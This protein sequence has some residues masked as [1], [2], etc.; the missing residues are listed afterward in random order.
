MSKSTR[1]NVLKGGLALGAATIGL[2]MAGSRVLAANEPIKIGIVAKL[3]IPWFDNIEVGIK[4]AAK[5]LDV[6][7]FMVFPPSDDAAQQVRAI[8][9]LIA[10]QVNVIGFMP[11]DA[12]ALEPVTQRAR[13]A[14]IIVIS[15]ELPGQKNV[16]WDIELIQDRAF[17]EAHMEAFAQAVGG[18]GKYVT[19]VGGLTVDVH[20]NWMDMAVEYQKA[21]YPDM[22]QIGDRF[23][24]ANSVEDSYRTAIDQ[25]RAHPD[26]A[27]IFI[28]GAAG[29]IGAGRAVQ[30]KERIGE[31][32]VVGPFIPSQGQKLMNAGAITRGF[33][34]N[35]Q[36]AG[37][38]LVALGK[39]LAEGGEVTDGMDLP[40]LGPV[41][42]DPE[43][44]SLRANAQID[45]NPESID[46]WAKI[47]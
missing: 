37:Y 12:K 10:Q 16:D 13:E 7:A 31:V 11:N 21:N 33:L 28:F 4:K 40:G 9:D 27:G 41:E 34:W 29:P 5:D 2:P 30:E 20:M 15:H 17:A 25:M 32:I 47:I 23:G 36:D 18:T 26:L 24:V 46:M 1:R 35:P 6:D 22:K 44:K 3:R 42:M 8:E 39:L 45:L 19:Y 14:G 43:L 38:G